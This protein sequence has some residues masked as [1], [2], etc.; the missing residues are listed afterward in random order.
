MKGPP[1]A[2]AKMSVDGLEIAKDKTGIGVS[3]TNLSLD[4]TAMEVKE[5]VNYDQKPAILLQTKELLEWSSTYKDAGGM[6]TMFGFHLLVKT[7]G[8][9][10]GCKQAFGVFEREKLEPLEAACRTLVKR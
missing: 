8:V 7:S 10:M 3:F 9:T 4:K 2:T 6:K 1:G 5:G